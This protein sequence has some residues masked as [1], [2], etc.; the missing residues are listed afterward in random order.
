MFAAVWLFAAVMANVE[1][2]NE[3][4]I[5]DS[6]DRDFET[7]LGD[8]ELLEIEERVS[9]DPIIIES[10]RFTFKETPEDEGISY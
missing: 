9:T 8:A 10:F 1:N 2:E 4:I 5:D 6:E 7:E 3:I